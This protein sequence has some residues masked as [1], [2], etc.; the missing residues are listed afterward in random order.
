[1]PPYRQVTRFRGT[2]R[3]CGR[4]GSAMEA[5]HH[6]QNGMF[7]CANNHVRCART[8]SAMDDM[9]DETP[10]APR[11]IAPAAG[12]CVPPIGCPMGTVSLTCRCINSNHHAPQYP[13]AGTGNASSATIAI[14]VSWETSEGKRR[15]KKRSASHPNNG[16]LGQKMTGRTLY[17]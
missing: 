15:V 7:H 1:M 4:P 5:V 12:I 13:A 17:G 14:L 2:C 3:C 8:V 11:A 16:I 10:K 9:R 6:P